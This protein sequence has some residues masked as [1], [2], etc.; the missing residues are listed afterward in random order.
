MTTTLS[1]P[2]TPYSTESLFRS[3]P[4]FYATGVLL[5]LSLLVTVP[6]MMMDTRLFQGENVW[7]KPIK[8]QFALSVYMLTLAFFARYLPD[9]MTSKRSYKVFAGIVVFSVV[10]EIIWIGGAAMY[11][12]ASHFNNTSP[13]MEAI[14]PLMGA[15]AVMLTL[16]SPV[17][18]IAIWRN[19]STGLEE[20]LKQSIALGLI[21][22]FVLTVPVA[23]TLSSMPGH[24]IGTP[25]SANSLPL[26]GWSTEVGDLRVSHFLATHA[27][28]F[29]P[30][31][32]LAASRL[33]PQNAAYWVV[34]GS[35]AAFCALVAATLLQA[36]AGMPFIATG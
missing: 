17:Y 8:F 13:F 23:G 34:W 9:G 29:I 5:A 12:I 10:A 30:L 11:G 15:F 35:S 7:I 14:Y 28:H 27:L 18:G 16:A 25:L 19:R 26:F 4:L 1:V 32:G 22:T 21:L 2:R 36:L 20:P 6:A 3:E 31:A 24:L 33:L